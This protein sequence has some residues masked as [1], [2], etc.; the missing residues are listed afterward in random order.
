MRYLVRFLRIFGLLLL[1][2]I[3]CNLFDHDPCKGVDCGDGNPC[4]RDYCYVG[5]CEA[6]RCAHPPVEN[7]TGC[8][9]RGA[10]GV[11]I[12]GVCDLCAGVVCEDDGNPCTDDV[13]D[14]HTGRCGV[15]AGDGTVCEYKGL[16]PGFCASGFCAKSLCEDGVCDDG[17]ECTDDTCDPMARRCDYAPVE[18]GTTCNFDGFRSVCISGIC[19]PECDSPEDCDDRNECTEDLCANGV[20]DLVPVED[21]TACRDDG[22]ECTADMCANGRCEGTPLEDG[23]ACRDGAGACQ[24]GS[25]V[26]LCSEQGIRDAIAEGGGPH[27][28][29][30]DGPTTVRTLEEIVIDNDVILDGAGNLTVDAG[31]AHRVFSVTPNITAELRGMTVTGGASQDDGGGIYNEGVLTITASAVSGNN[32]ARAG[33]GIC[34][35]RGVL[36]LKNS[37]ISVNTSVASGGGICHFGGVLTLVNTTVS[38]NTASGAGAGGGGIMYFGDGVGEEIVLTLINS[39]VSNNAAESLGGGVASGGVLA[40]TNST[41]SGNTARAGGGILNAK[42]LRLRNSTISGNTTVWRIGSAIL[43]SDGTGSPNYEAMAVESAGTLIDGE[44]SHFEE[45][46]AVSNGYNIES[47]GKTCRFDRPTDQ[48][49][50][51]AEDLKLGPLEDNGGLTETH[52]LLPGSVAIDRIPERACIDADGNALTTDQRGEPRPETAGAMCDIGAFEVQP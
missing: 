10:S 40:M 6:A 14:P 20:C 25:C 16:F 24:A 12:N 9:I 43:N 38:A 37:T 27:F 17:N 13:C 51:S 49:N 28:F 26:N 5:E 41:V 50:V 48:V 23:T 42:V 36:T 7:G 34:T 31:G 47:P 22:N 4:T 52:A 8:S 18:D 1:P 19:Q 39:T 35:N 32:A 3:G 45:I 46:A 33:G 2:F 30:C 11:C 15:P 44:C 21:G 29:A